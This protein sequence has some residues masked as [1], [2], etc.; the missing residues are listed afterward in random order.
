M[1]SPVNSISAAR[2]GPIIPGKSAASITD[3][4]PTRTSGSPSKASAAAVRTSHAIA[5]S[6]PA[7]RHA[8][9]TMQMVGNGAS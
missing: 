6:K 4:T 5:S 3:G 7:P 2:A 8:P 9:F 1:P